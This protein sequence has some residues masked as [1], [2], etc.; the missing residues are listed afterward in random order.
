MTD[1]SGGW[2]AKTG[3]YYTEI[4]AQIDEAFKNVDI[5]LKDAG[6]KGWEQVRV[7]SVSVLIANTYHVSLSVCLEKGS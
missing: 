2:D 6:G 7:V 3:E 5:N 4:N 1:I